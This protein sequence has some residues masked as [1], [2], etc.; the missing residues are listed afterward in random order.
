VVAAGAERK[1][2]AWTIESRTRAELA[3]APARMPIRVCAA[4]GDHH[5]IAPIRSPA[6]RVTVWALSGVRRSH[7]PH[8]NGNAHDDQEQSAGADDGRPGWQ[9]QLIGCQQAQ[10]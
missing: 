5:A 2:N 7:A 8:H 6:D 9:V 4:A 3:V 1:A 10:Q